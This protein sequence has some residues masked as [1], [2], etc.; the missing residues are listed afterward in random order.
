MGW[1]KSTRQTRLDGCGS[2]GYAAVKVGCNCDV[3]M[4]GHTPSGEYYCKRCGQPFRYEL[5]GDVYTTM[6]DLV[7]HCFR[8][9]PSAQG[10]IAAYIAK[11]PLEPIA[12]SE[13]PSEPEGPSRDELLARISELEADVRKAV[14]ERDSEVSKLLSENEGLRNENCRLVSECSDLEQSYTHERAEA[15]RLRSV[16]VRGM[17]D[18]FLEFSAG[19]FNTVMDNDDIETVRR[20]TDVRLERFND[21]LSV[22]GLYMHMQKRGEPVESGRMDITEVPTDDPSRDLTVARSM[23]FGCKF[24]T[25]AFADIP[26]SV[27]V[28]RYRPPESQEAASAEDVSDETEEKTE[29]GIDDRPGEDRRNS[30]ADE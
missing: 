24:R 13:T 20:I 29:E 15:D 23:R 12:A 6:E 11:N 7:L 16:N 4:V 5:E 26:E 21:S 9:T 3:R 18:A 22:C 14:E 10:Q 28:Y 8:V 17:A 19:T 27:A 1:P 25:D 2:H 30:D